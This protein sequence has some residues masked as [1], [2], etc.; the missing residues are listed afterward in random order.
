VSGPIPGASRRLRSSRRLS[1]AACNAYVTAL[2]DVFRINIANGFNGTDQVLI[3]F[4]ITS[5]DCIS[6]T[7]GQTSEV[8]ELV[9]QT[10]QKCIIGDEGCSENGKDDSDILNNTLSSVK[11]TVD[12]SITGSFNAEFSAAFS[13]IA[14][15]T[16]IDP[17]ETAAITDIIANSEPPVN[18]FDLNQDAQIETVVIT[19][20]PTTSPTSSVSYERGDYLVARNPV[21]RLKILLFSSQR[22]NQP[23]RRLRT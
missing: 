1:V 17:S 7:R 5:I 8:Y 23:P 18:K 19:K 16:G 21:Y 20:S 9:S 4:G 22:L 14:N 3:S 15:E 13:A 2:E 6:G 12:N 10:F 11:A